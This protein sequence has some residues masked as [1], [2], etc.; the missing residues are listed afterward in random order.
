MRVF[1]CGAQM[2]VAGSARPPA[3]TFTLAFEPTYMDRHPVLSSV[4]R[5]LT[6]DHTVPTVSAKLL[7]AT[8][9]D[10]TDPEF[11]IPQSLPPHPSLVVVLGTCATYVT[12]FK[13]HLP[14][15]FTGSLPPASKGRFVFT[16]A[17]TRTLG[18]VGALSQ[19]QWTL[20]ALQLLEVTAFVHAHHIAHC[21]IT[22]SGAVGGLCRH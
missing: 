10:A 6:P 20:A 21:N 11:S 14:P 5:H 2:S 22:V 3:Y 12:S 17:Y 9:P 4:L 13:Y 8:T 18:D 19:P 15:S 16:P 7:V 1:A